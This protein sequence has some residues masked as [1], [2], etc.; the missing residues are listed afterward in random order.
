MNRKSYIWN[1]LFLFWALHFWFGHELSGNAIPIHTDWSLLCKHDTLKTNYVPRDWISSNYSIE[2][3]KAATSFLEFHNFSEKCAFKALKSL[4]CIDPM[5][6]WTGHPSFE[7]PGAAPDTLL[8]LASKFKFIL[9]D[10]LYSKV[11][12]TEMST[13]KLESSECVSIHSSS[14]IFGFISGHE[15]FTWQGY[16]APW[17]QIWQYSFGHERFGQNYWFRVLRQYWWRWKEEYN[18]WNTLL[19]GSRNR[20]QKTLW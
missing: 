7:S 19:D 9:E 15:L 11:F 12:L 3:E 6:F 14:S 17:Y 20:I 8:P 2:L 5:N 4:M 1:L 10:R 18:G 13:I 16:F